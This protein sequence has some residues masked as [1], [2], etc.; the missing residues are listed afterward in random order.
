MVKD[1]SKIN[2]KKLERLSHK[3]IIRDN[4]PLIREISHDVPVPLNK[5]DRIIMNQMINKSP[6]D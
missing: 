6:S 2:T 1:L 5:D 4:N 3:D